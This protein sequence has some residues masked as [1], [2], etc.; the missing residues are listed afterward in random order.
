[1]INNIF[2]LLLTN[3]N[4]K[5]MKVK[6]IFMFISILIMNCSTRNYFLVEVKNPVFVP[7]TVFIHMRTSPLQNSPILLQNT[8]W[9]QYSTVKPMNSKE[10]YY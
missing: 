4:N 7:N 10:Y 9:I 2:Y 8:G 6:V 3:Y 1:M 5:K